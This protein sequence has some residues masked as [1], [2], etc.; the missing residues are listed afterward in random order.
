MEAV[1]AGRDAVATARDDEPERVSY[2]DHLVSSLQALRKRT[3]DLSTLVDEVQVAREVADATP[4]GHPKRAARL[5]SLH[6][7]LDALYARTADNAILA[8]ALQAIRDAVAS[9]HDQD[10]NLGTYLYHLVR[11]LPEV[12]KHTGEMS[13]LT[14][15]AQAG[16]DAVAASTNAA[17]T[18]ARS[19]ILSR[20]LQVLFAQSHDVTILTEAAQ[21][22]RD[23]ATATPTGDPEYGVTQANLGFCLRSLSRYTEDTSIL[24]E[25]RQCFSRV[26]HAPA[27]P[28]RLRIEAACALASLPVSAGGSPKDVLAAMETAVSL[29]PQVAPRAFVRADR[30]HNLSQ[31]AYLAAEAAA[32]AIGAGQPGR[33]VKLLEQ[34]RGILTADTLDARSS[35]LTK[36]RDSLPE[37]AMELDE[38][39]ARI[40]FLDHPEHERSDSTHFGSEL[41]QLRQD[42]HEAWDNLVQRIRHEGFE[43]FLQPR[44]VR[45]LALQAQDGPIIFVNAGSSRCDGLIITDDPAQLVQV[46][47]LTGLTQR[48]AVDQTIRLFAA[49]LRATDNTVSPADRI[50]AQREI[51]AVLAWM[52]IV[53]T[54]PIL[55]A[56]GHTSTPTA[57]AVWP[58]VW[59]C[60]GGILAHMP[61]HASGDHLARN[62]E[63][64]GRPTVMDRVVSSYITTLRGLEY[65]R[66][67]RPD[68][69]GKTLIIA[70]PDAPAASPLSGV[71]AESRIIADRVPGAH[72]LP[73]P[74]RSTVLAEL[75][76]HL[77][78]HFACHGYADL[79]RPAASRLL[80]H[81]HLETPLTVA[82]I[83]ALRL[84]GGLAY[85]AACDTAFTNPTL[86][87][88][89]LHITGA[90]HLAGYQH[91][92]GSL[93]PVIDTT[94]HTI[95]E[96]FYSYLT[97]SGARPP[98]IDRAAQAL[99][100]ATRKMRDQYP[101]TP[102]TWA[103][104]THTGL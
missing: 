93:W 104:H 42:A 88:Q 52:W 61:L 12:Y 43:E 79:T 30:E 95:A 34:T 76:T 51:L 5:N 26:A 13:A 24:V 57:D 29:L 54:G 46:V 15:A 9:A 33:A 35:D 4:V 92:I 47:P 94:A 39:R 45:E 86:A 84:P 82:D 81:D 60:P 71:I 69:A 103:G 37:L 7:S 20:A 97:D 78:A 65:A 90:C 44:T 28:A 83:S 100:H 17:E 58:R 66:N 102:T 38:Q 32:A 21:L 40:D 77:V 68:P 75:P 22:A 1:Q 74:T 10:R 27:A 19:N 23:A 14:E 85:L 87:D 18:A 36:L 48:D 72:A 67:Q 101:L 63:E 50:A 80:L 62:E 25:A 2:R 31:V 91:V 41:S 96:D 49:R 8:E 16:R 11:I 6:I 55:A 53:I 70:V 64:Q 73:H 98:D 59:W 56:L 99:H 89:A 3:G